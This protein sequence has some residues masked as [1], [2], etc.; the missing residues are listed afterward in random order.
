[1]RTSCPRA[2]RASDRRRSC[3]SGIHADRPSKRTLEPAPR[4]GA[5][6]LERIEVTTA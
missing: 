6:S 2:C 3:S 1:M 5:R 4:R